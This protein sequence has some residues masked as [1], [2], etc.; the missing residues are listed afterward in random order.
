MDVEAPRALVRLFDQVE[1]PR[2]ERSKLH[3]L[4]DILIITLC[5]VICG[6]DTWTEVELFGRAKFAWLR[7]FLKLPHGIP[8]HDT[9]G[10]VFARLNPDQL[11]RC[12]R[13]WMQGLAEASGGR[14]IALDGKTIRRSFN[15]TDGKGAIHMVSAW[16]QANHLVLGQLATDEKSNE[17]KA[18]PQLLALLDI[19]DAVVTIDAMGCQKGI[20]R[21]IVEQGGHYLLQ[22]KKNQDT[23]YHR[24]K[25]TFD[26]LTVRP[27]RGAPYSFH[28]DVGGGQGR[29]GIRRVW[30]TEWTDWYAQRGQWVGL[31]S[32]VCVESER[33]A[34]G[35]TSTERRYYISDL[36]GDDAQTLLGYV[37]GHWGI[38]NQLHWSLDVAFR[39]D[40]LRQRIGHSAE[41]LSRIRRLALN[42][43]RRDKT[44]R[45]GIKAKRLQACLKNDYLLRVLSQG[46]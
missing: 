18:I 10:R 37:R 11:E 1:D 40:T 3:S 31:R 26:E 39:E 33:T 24:I 19:T 42:L 35:H 32:F 17:I 27:I 4:S 41:N 20:A 12:F 7:T 8:S 9:F 34:Q 2:V 23:L 38:E 25:E 13:A 43:L 15:K 6:A 21:Q 5:A 30:A 46:I 29:V 22:V 36:G 14:L 16:C 28:Q 45:A 44:C